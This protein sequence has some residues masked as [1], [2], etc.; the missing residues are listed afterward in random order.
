[1]GERG[2]IDGS[3]LPVEG[4]GVGSVEDGGASVSS[5]GAVHRIRV[6]VKRPL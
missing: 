1:M 4:S 3:G 6:R 2:P 5:E